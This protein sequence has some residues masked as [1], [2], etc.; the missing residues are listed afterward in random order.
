MVV[1]Q[2]DVST[3]INLLT[4]KVIAN[5]VINHVQSVP[6]NLQDALNAQKDIF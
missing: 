6:K 4:K 5:S 3:K 1:D 2:E